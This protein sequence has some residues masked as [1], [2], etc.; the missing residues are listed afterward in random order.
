MNIEN[1]SSIRLY[2]PTNSSSPPALFCLNFWSFSITISSL[3]SKS[4]KS[5]PLSPST[6]PVCIFSRFSL[7]NT[8]AKILLNSSTLSSTGCL[9]ILP[10]ES[11]NGPSDTV[12]LALLFAYAKCEVQTCIWPSGCHCQ[13]LSLASVKSIFV[14]PFWY[15]LTRVVPYKGLLNGS[16]FV[17]AKK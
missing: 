6:A 11:I 13:S 17:Y 10:D 16:V 8:D 1:F 5:Q 4:N 2:S 14:F 15:R 3:M 12:H 7:V 9:Q